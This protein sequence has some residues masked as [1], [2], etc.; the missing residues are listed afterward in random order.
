MTEGQT[1]KIRM[2]CVAMAMKPTTMK[3]QD[4]PDA[5]FIFMQRLHQPLLEKNVHVDYLPVTGPMSRWNYLWAMLKIFYWSITGK[6][7]T[8][9][10]IHAHYGFNGI[11]ARCQFRKPVVVT[12]MGSDVYI[13]WQGRIGRWLA[14]MVSAVIVQQPRMIEILNAPLDR[15]QVIPYGVDTR[16]FYPT[17]SQKAREDL[18]LPADKKLVCFPYNPVRPEKRYDLVSAATELIDNAEIVTVYNQPPEIV[19]K[20]MNACD[21]MIMAS[22]HEGSPVAVREALACNLPVVSVDVGDVKALIADVPG[23]YLAERDP[24]DIA[25]KLRQVFV[26]NQ[27]LATGFDHIAP[28]SIDAVSQKL[29]DLYVKVSS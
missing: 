2:L 3:I 5:T 21:A 12:F 18:G 7:N 23:C 22:D 15:T 1:R 11:V 4:N 27:R 9:D 16:I 14:R 26:A 24:A 17:D 29:R 13:P 20:H 19:A 8:Y 6:L 10:V 28:T 25:D